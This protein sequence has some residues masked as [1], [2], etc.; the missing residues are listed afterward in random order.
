MLNWSCSADKRSQVERAGKLSVQ[1]IEP[2]ILSGP[3]IEG[4]RWE[5][6]K[7]ISTTAAAA[8]KRTREAVD[9]RNTPW[10]PQVVK[11]LSYTVDLKDFSLDYN[12]VS[13]QYDFK[14]NANANGVPRDTF[15][16]RGDGRCIME[17]TA[18][19]V[20]SWSPLVGRSYGDLVPG[21]LFIVAKAACDALNTHIAARTQ[22]AEK[23]V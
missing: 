4:V 6:K 10:I 11:D 12:P 14:Y 22:S 5:V 9:R 2:Y 3:E 21:E 19:G 18:A 15:V 7:A 16:I 23:D 20:Y 13:Q 8:A 1:E 17:K